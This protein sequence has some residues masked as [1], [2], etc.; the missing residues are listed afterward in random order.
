MAVLRLQKEK[1]PVIILSKSY[2][3]ELMHCHL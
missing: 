2:V 1:K 3:L